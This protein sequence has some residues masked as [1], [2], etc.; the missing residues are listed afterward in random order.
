MKNK[1]LL[2][3]ILGVA[4]FASCSDDD[5][6]PFKNYSAD[7]S[8][9]KLALKLNGKEFSGTSVS[10]NSE[11][12]KNATLTLNKLIPGEPALEVKNLIVEELAGDD[13]TFAGENKN[14]DRIV[15]VEGAVKSGVLSLN[16]SFKVISKVVGE[17]MLAKPEMDDS[18][19]MVSSCIHLEIVTDVDSIA[20]PIWGKLPINPNPEIEG[21][22]GLTTLL[23][24]LGGGILPGLLK[25]MNLKED[26]NLIASYHQITGIQDLFQPDATPLVDSEEGLVRYNVKDGQIYILVDIESLL[27]RSTE[28]NPTSMLM[29]M[30]ETGIPL[31]VQLDGEKMRAYVDREMMLPFMSVLELLLPMIDDLELDPNFAAMGITNESLKQLVNDI[32]N[33]VTKSSKVEL[34]LNLTSFVEDEETQ[35]SLALPKVIEET[36]FQLAK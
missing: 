32:I 10:F 12:K 27:G 31:K 1:F 19:N 5:K 30:L 26:G 25:K 9:D 17:W 8:G 14:D 11:N 33:L 23:Q 36:V 35:A 6:D 34:G 28:N 22:L 4:F 20:F 16:T 21:D 2:L 15:L 7:Y 13:Y 3:L 29:T 18:Y 24:T